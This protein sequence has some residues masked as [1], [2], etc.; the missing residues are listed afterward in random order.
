MGEVRIGLARQLLVLLLAV[1][2]VVGYL[3]LTGAAGYVGGGV[4]EEAE[5]SLIGGGGT[6][7]AGP[8]GKSGARPAPA[9]QPFILLSPARAV[10]PATV[11]LAGHRFVPGEAVA[12]TVRPLAGGE[13]RQV[14]SA[15]ADEEGLVPNLT[16]QVPEDLGPGRFVVEARGEGG[17]SAS[18]DLEVLPAAPWVRLDPYAAKPRE[19]IVFAAGGFRPGETVAVYLNTL[20]G[21]ALAEVAAS[22][23]GEVA[24]GR[25]TLPFAGKGDNVLLFIGRQSRVLAQSKFTVLAYTPYGL[26]GN[27][28]PQPLQTIDLAGE[29][30]VPGELVLVYLDEVDGEPVASLRADEKGKVA[31]AQAFSVPLGMEGEH[32]LIYVGEHSQLP[33]PA[34]FT[35]MPLTPSLE[36]T[37]YAVRPGGWVAFNG[38]GFAKGETLRAYVGEPKPGA[39]VSSFQADDEGA[40]AQAGGFALPYQT[41]GE[42]VTLTVVGDASRTPVASEL[43]VIGLEPSGDVS[44]YYAE[45]GSEVTFGGYGFG[46]GEEIAVYAGAGRGQ[47]VATARADA[48]GSFKGA[49]PYRLPVEAKDAASFAILGVQ[50][51]A[52]AKVEVK[53]GQAPTPPPGNDGGG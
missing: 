42:A 12:V 51:G 37:I 7:T 15:A 16:F 5:P 46:A 20:D 35:V 8:P 41:S 31:A 48:D 43:G 2:L 18:A 19:E 34:T 21:E 1:A 17:A 49:G 33:A 32:S 29:A 26:L 24:K 36:L 44:A 45:P 52:E 50:T 40:F 3:Y 4:E 22:E 13:P 6:G 38:R 14:G 30:F 10:Y 39:E 47:P 25:L 28:T 27:Y 9:G 11:N 23:T 53:V